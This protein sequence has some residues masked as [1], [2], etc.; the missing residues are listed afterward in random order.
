[1]S[2]V[3]KTSAQ[4]VVLEV[5]GDAALEGRE[6]CSVQLEALLA[7][8]PFALVAVAEL[9]AV[10][11][12]GADCAGFDDPEAWFPLEAEP[13]QPVTR[14][15]R[16]AERV[17]AAALCGFCP[18][19]AQCAPLSFGL[20]PRGL[21]GV[22]GGL[23]ARD[24]L[25]LRPLWTELRRRLA[26]E[27]GIKVGEPGDEHRVVEDEVDEAVPLRPVV[28]AEPAREGTS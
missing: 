14:Q 28:V 15:R 22:W 19:R 2:P 9:D 24:R 3:S 8:A 25:V 18:V 4:R 1:M 17:E 20:G 5:A 27:G 13:D 6:V 23:S 12:A 21:Y 11:T 16:L 26:E 10:V 7:A